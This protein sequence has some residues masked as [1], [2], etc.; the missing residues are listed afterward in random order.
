MG[1]TIKDMDKENNLEN[2]TKTFS[3][4]KKENSF[5]ELIEQIEKVSL[6]EISL[7]KQI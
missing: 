7:I 6:H 1:E 5:G 2:W 4:D 3:I